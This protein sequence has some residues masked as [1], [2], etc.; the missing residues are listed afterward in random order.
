MMDLILNWPFAQSCTIF[1]T[2]P[3]E[4]RPDRSELY[5]FSYKIAWKMAG[6]LGVVRFFVQNR[7]KK[8]QTYLAP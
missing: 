2:K 1:R 6:P 8:G 5:D 7:L 4:K 3:L